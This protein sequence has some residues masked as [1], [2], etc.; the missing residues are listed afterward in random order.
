M[1]RH[2]QVMTVNL[3]T[4]QQEAETQMSILA[5]ERYQ[6]VKIDTVEID[7]WPTVFVTD[8]LLDTIARVM[9]PA[10]ASRTG[11]ATEDIDTDE[12]EG[13]LPTTSSAILDVNDVSESR[14]S[15]LLDQLE[16]MEKNIIINVVVGSKIMQHYEDDAYFT[17]AFPKLFPW[18]TA[19]HRDDRRLVQLPLSTWVSLMLRNSSR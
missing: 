3:N 15:L 7:S 10:A 2:R 12:F 17:S 13:D 6:N 4:E 18:G 5:S 11:I 16:R 14:D 19:K 8:Q 1:S 9:D